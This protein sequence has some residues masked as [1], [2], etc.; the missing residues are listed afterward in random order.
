MIGSFEIFKVVEGGGGVPY[1]TYSDES[2]AQTNSW[3]LPKLLFLR[4]MAV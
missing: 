1:S 3:A 2:A 4:A